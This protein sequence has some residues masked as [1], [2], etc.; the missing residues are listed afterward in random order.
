MITTLAK[1]QIM[2]E[3]I[4][5]FSLLN[6]DLTKHFMLSFQIRLFLRGCS[7]STRGHATEPG[8]SVLEAPLQLF[9][10]DFQCITQLGDCDNTQVLT[11]PS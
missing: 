6:R 11:L 9:F 7:P 3:D 4:W 1:P 2:K 8:N 10:E 5:Y